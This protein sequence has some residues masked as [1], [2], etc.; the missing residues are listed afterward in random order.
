MILYLIAR[1]VY[2]YFGKNRQS[3]PTPLAETLPP[4]QE[5]E[6][7][8]ENKVGLEIPEDVE[9]AKLTDVTGKGA[10]AIVSRK[11]TQGKYE[12]NLLA[13]LPETEDG[14]FYQVWLSR[15]N[16]Q[17]SVGKLEE[18][19]GGWILNFTTGE[20]KADYNRVTVTRETKDD[21]QPE[22]KILEGEF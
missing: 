1:F 15:Q 10:L 5:E 7:A 19:K 11:F 22:E 13:S 9:K 18:E 12:Y 6:L 21:N 2:S 3:T 20:D 17:I 8:L 4:T 14:K 16:D